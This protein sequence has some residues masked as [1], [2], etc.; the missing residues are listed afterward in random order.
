M[1]RSVATIPSDRAF[2]TSDLP[3]RPL[4]FISHRPHI[5]RMCNSVSLMQLRVRCTQTIKD[6]NPDHVAEARR[7]V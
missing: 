7:F 5:Y 4:G 6:W 1:M 3:P 2:F